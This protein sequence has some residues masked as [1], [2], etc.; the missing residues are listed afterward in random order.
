MEHER[1]KE[2]IR[3]SIHISSLILPLSYRYL[4]HNHRKNT[5]VILVPLTVIALVIEIIRL[6][7]R[8][9][10]RIFYNIFGIM[11]RK[12]EIHDFTGATYLMIST[13]LCIAIFPKDIAF[14]SLCFL[15]IGDTL[16]ATVGISFGKRKL[17]GTRKS[18]EG[19]L[20]CF[21]STFIFALF[22]IDPVIAFFG[23]IA[24]TLSE[25]SRLPVDDN[26][27]IPIASGMVMSLVNIFV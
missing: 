17:F 10:K 4:F 11:L 15:A 20:A 18:L 26:I 22:F 1:K 21:I 16:A 3:K 19:S 27:K 9:F 14:L 8:T 25:F 7:H 24:A 2:L 6:E 5:F 12:H 23:A 13:I